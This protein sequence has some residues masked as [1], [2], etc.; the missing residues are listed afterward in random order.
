MSFL[1]NDFARADHGEHPLHRPTIDCLQSGRF[2]RSRDPTAPQRS[3]MLIFRDD[4]WISSDIARVTSLLGP[5][6]IQCW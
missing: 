3:P 1:A 2:E 5:E 6:Y 4:V